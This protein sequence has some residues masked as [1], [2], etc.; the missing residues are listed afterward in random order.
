[1]QRVWLSFLPYTLFP[2]GSGGLGCGGEETS[3]C[4]PGLL[5]QV[6]GPPPPTPGVSGMG[7]ATFLKSTPFIPSSSHKTCI[8]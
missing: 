8:Y 6:S 4:H 3:G 5:L 7:P 1:M 2:S